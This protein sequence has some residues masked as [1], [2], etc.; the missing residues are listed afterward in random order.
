MGETSVLKQPQAASSSVQR[1][2]A[3]P[4]LGATALPDPTPRAATALPDTP[5]P[6]PALWHW[7]E[8]RTA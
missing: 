6:K 1:I 8:C 4:L 3:P 7:Y 2:L 5:P